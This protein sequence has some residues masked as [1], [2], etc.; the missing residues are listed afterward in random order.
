MNVSPFSLSLPT[1]PEAMVK[2][3]VIGFFLV[4]SVVFSYAQV[5][6]NTVY[7]FLNYSYSARNSG[8]GGGLISS[9]SD[10]PTLIMQNPSVISDRFHTSFGVN[11]VDYFSNVNYGSAFYSHTFKKLGSFAFEMRYIGYGTF[12]QTDESGNEMGAFTA[13]DYAGTIGWGRKL[14]DRISIGANLKLIY[15]GYE[16][17]SSFGLATDVAGTYYNPDKKFSM[18]LLFKNMGSQISTYTPGNFENLPFD[19]QFALSKQLEHVPVRLHLSIHSLYKWDMTYEGNDN[20]LLEVDAI[21]GEYKYPSAFSQQVNNFFRH[22]TFGLEILPSDNFSLFASFNYNRN[23]EMYI[24]QNKSAAGFSYGFAFNI[25]TFR[26]SFARSHYAVGAAPITLNLASNI[27][28]L[29]HLKKPNK[30]IKKI[31]PQN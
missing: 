10:D 6:K 21:T 28:D 30:K 23:R 7:N 20:P 8:L 22:F 17:Y 12:T 16:S 13:G 25:K 3:F 9:Y 31:T 14:S 27:N 1:I 5:G 15:S 29:Y 19:I 26:F 2:K 11:F 24:P 18:S 4:C